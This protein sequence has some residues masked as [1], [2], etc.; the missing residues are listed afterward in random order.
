[1][2]AHFWNP[3]LLVPL[4]EIVCGDDTDPEVAE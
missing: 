2:T 3:P 1:M 4:V